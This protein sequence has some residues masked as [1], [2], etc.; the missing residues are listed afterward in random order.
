M[1]LTGAELTT[2]LWVQFNNNLWQCIGAVPLS[3]GGGLCPH[4]TQCRQAEAA[5]S[6]SNAMWV[7]PRPAFVPTTKLHL[8]FGYSL[9][10]IHD[11]AWAF[12]LL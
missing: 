11:N 2:A 1:N 9:I 8:Q 3:G 6:S 5:G 4:L 12:M 10:I 7:G